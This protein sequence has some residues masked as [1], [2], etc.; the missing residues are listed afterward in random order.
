[1]IIQRLARG[2]HGFGEL[3]RAMPSV[4]A[5]VLREQLRQLQA[6]GLVK[7]RALAPARLGVRYAL[8]PYAKTLNPV[9]G[10]L[11]KWGMQHLEKSDTAGGTR[12]AHDRRDQRRRRHRRSANRRFDL[13]DVDLLHLHHRF[14]RAPGLFTAGRECVGE[15]GWGD[16]PGH[17]PLVLAPAA[18]AF[19]TAIRDD[20]VPVAIG[21]FLT[22]RRD[23][24]RKCFGRR[25]RGTVQPDTRQPE[26]RELHGEHVAGFPAGS[27]GARS[28]APTRLFG[29]VSA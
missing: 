23:L 18:L 20:G 21:F 25:E 15:D 13:R 14:E 5:K 28:T 9:F 10:A 7:R 17:S 22:G 19:L 27:P 6:D 8:T 3:Q 4:T 12:L 26:D 16:L 11:V 24:K 29:N 2:P 1:M